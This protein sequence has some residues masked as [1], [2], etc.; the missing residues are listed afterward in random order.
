MIRLLL[1]GGPFMFATLAVSVI[2][3][4][5]FIWRCIYLWGRAK[6]SYTMLGQIVGHLEA[7]E[8]TQ[9]LRLAGSDQS[10]LGKVLLGAL[11][12]ANRTE[13]EIRRAVETVALDEIPRVRGATVYL[14]QLSNLA[15]LC[16]LI[17]TIHGLIIAFQGAGSENAAARQAILSQGISI[18]FYNTF[19]G[20][21]VATVTIVFYLVLLAKTN[22]VLGLIERAA[23]SVIDSILWYRDPSRK[24]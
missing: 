13:R 20:L 21:S 8:V 23:A 10:P 9:A 6:V 1:A 16:G 19:F 12:R 3:V 7:G 17:G 5:I 2:T 18:A 14:P 4:A 22:S 11:K 15:T 24:V